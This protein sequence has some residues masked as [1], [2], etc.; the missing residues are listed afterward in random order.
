MT[1][2]SIYESISGFLIKKIIIFR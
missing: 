2:S 1:H